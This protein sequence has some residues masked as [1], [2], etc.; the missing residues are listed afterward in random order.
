MA[1]TRLTVNPSLSWSTIKSGREVLLSST[2]TIYSTSSWSTSIF[3]GNSLSLTTILWTLAFTYCSSC[4]QWTV[5]QAVQS[6]G[7]S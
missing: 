2:S 5:L 4:L 3:S 7:L 1:Y 6:G